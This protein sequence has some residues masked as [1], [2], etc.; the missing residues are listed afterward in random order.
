MLRAS[1]VY[2]VAPCLGQLEQT[3]PGQQQRHSCRAGSNDIPKLPGLGIGAPD[4]AGLRRSQR[5]YDQRKC[6]VQGDV[7]GHGQ[8]YSTEAVNQI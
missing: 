8:H 3:Q 6:L 2:T 1:S 7:Y 5:R 4:R